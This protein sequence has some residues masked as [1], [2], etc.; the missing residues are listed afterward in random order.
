LR[1]SN[2]DVSAL[3]YLGKRGLVPGRLLEVK[4][5]RAVDGVAT[6][7]DEDGTSHSLGA[8]L[9]GSLFVRGLSAGND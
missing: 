5:V 7:E 2:E 9:A 3:A 8:P 1:V 4:E 6:V